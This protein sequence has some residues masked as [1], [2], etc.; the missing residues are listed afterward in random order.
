MGD[1]PAPRNDG[2]GFSIEF[3]GLRLQM[4]NLRLIPDLGIRRGFMGHETAR[5]AEW[6][7]EKIQL[8]RV[9]HRA[10]KRL[11]EKA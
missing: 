10:K 3:I 4:E 6:G 11:R 1:L 9:F 8:G 2:R 5:I 7:I